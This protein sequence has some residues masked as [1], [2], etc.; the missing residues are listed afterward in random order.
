MANPLI[1]KN[2][3]SLSVQSII[4]A[5]AMRRSNFDAPTELLLRRVVIQTLAGVTL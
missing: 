2:E 1:Y 4:G 3:R 5:T